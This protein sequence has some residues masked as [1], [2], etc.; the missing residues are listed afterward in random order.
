MALITRIILIFINMSFVLC[1][2][3]YCVRMDYTSFKCNYIPTDIPNGVSSVRLWNFKGPNLNFTINNTFFRT[4]NWKK[5]KKLE[6]SYNVS[7]PFSHFNFTSACFVGLHSL[8]ELH[9]HILPW[10]IMNSNVFLGLEKLSLLDLD[11]CKRFPLTDLIPCLNGMTKLPRLQ[12]LILSKLNSLWDPIDIDTRFTNALKD[13]NISSLD[14]SSTVISNINFTALSLDMNKLK[15]LNISHSSISNTILIFTTKLKQ[16]NIDSFDASFST[17]FRFIPSASLVNI[18]KNI[19]DLPRWNF[20]LAP[21][22]VNYSNI[23]LGI[24]YIRIINSTIIVDKPVQWQS[25]EIILSKNH[26]KYLDIKI[27]SD[28]YTF[29]MITRFDL[30][31]NEL[32]FLHP[33]LTASVPNIEKL[34]L[35]KNQLFKMVQGH[36]LLFSQLLLS[37]RH[38]KRIN[39][40]SN[41]LSTIPT[42]MFIKSHNLQFIDLSWN[43]MEQVTFTLSHLEKLKVLLLQNNKI[44]DFDVLSM[45]NIDSVIA[46]ISYMT[47]NKLSVYLEYNPLSCSKCETEAFINWLLST[48]YVIIPLSHLACSDDNGSFRAIDQVTYKYVQGICRRRIIIISTSAAIGVMVLVALVT[49]V[50]VYRYRKKVQR[51]ANRI[52]LINKLH[53]GEGQYEF[54]VFL[55]YSNDEVFVKDYLYRNLD[56]NLKQMTRID[57][58]LICTSDTHVDGG[59]R[60]IGENGQCIERCSALIAVVSENYLIDPNCCLDLDSAGISQTPI[61]IFTNEATGEALFTQR[62]LKPFRKRPR[63]TWKIENNQYKMNTTFEDLYLLLLDIIANSD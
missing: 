7:E 48:K 34:D 38:L 43:Q 27:L 3:K 57:R 37:L 22:V 6:L 15:I 31:E 25:R 8:E 60:V 44:K 49:I 59:H 47:H 2:R 58:D 16:L 18:T 52:E 50:A 10:I 54:V 29:D 12:H 61:V 32:E 33:S 24:G 39:L 13:K 35:S 19:S 9:M 42:K 51:K 1:V 20:F 63:V 11:S 56:E 26:L 40:S 36:K 5:V 21:K 28:T 53:N 41:D 17:L 55:S 23:F 46:N 14:L 4:Y 30:A 45:R 62:T